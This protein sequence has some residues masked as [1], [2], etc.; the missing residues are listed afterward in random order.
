MNA[1]LKT[2]AFDLSHTTSEASSIEAGAGTDLFV[3]GLAAEEADNTN[4]QSA[5]MLDGEK[6]EMFC[7]SI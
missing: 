4:G 5:S 3:S 7:C 1:V 6:T 2:E